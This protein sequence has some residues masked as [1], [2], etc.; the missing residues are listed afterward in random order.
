M[1]NIFYRNT[2]LLILTIVLIIFWGLSS[3]QILPRLED[4]EL[5]PRLGNITTIFP[6]A[7]AER[8]ES[9]IT[10][11]IEDELKEIEAI[12]LISSVSRLGLSFITVELKDEIK[13]I[14]L[15]WSQIR[16][17]L[18]DVSVKLPAGSS[19]PEFE[20][21]KL[22][23]YSMILALTWEQND[24]VNYA[25]LRRQAELL[26]NELRALPG[27]EEVELRGEPEEEIL[28]EIDHENLL[29]LGLNT[30][31]LAQ[32]IKASD[33]K[34]SSGK[35]RNNN[36]DLLLEIDS[37]IDS[38][39]RIRQIPIST[40]NQGLTTT[41]GNIAILKKGIIEPPNDIA[42]IQGKE[43]IALT[44]IVR[45]DY[46]L[47][48]WA[49]NAYQTIN[50]FQ[51][52]L[53]TGLN[54]QIIFDQS[55]YVNLRLDNLIFNLI[56][57]A[58]LVFLITCLMMGLKSAL[59][60][61]SAL[62]LSG[63]IVFGCMRLFNIPLHQMSITGL[64]VALGLLI[65]NAIVMVDEVQ[66]HL[67][68]GI[69][70]SLAIKKSVNYLKIPL[71]SST[72]TTVLAFL[73]IALLP[74]PTGEFVGTI[75]INVIIALFSSLLLS[76]TIIPALTAKFSNSQQIN[77]NSWLQKGIDV[78]WLTKIYSKSLKFTFKRPILGVFLALI[79]PIFGFLKFAELEEQFFPVA[80]RDQFQIELE[81]PAITSINE[82]H[83]LLKQANEIVTSHQEVKEIHWFAGR[84]APKFYYNLIENK[85]NNASYA[86]ALVEVESDKIVQSLIPIIQKEL[87]QKFPQSRVL[88]KQLE[89]GPPFNAPVEM[90]IYGS[91]LDVL[92]NL[93]S[94]F[95]RELALIN[96]VTFTRDSLGEISPQFSLKVDE[97]KARLVGLDN[98]KIA[99]QLNDNLEGVI[100]GS[101]I[102]DTEEIPIRVRLSNSERGD[103][104]EINSLD[105]ASNNAIIPFSTVAHMEITPQSNAIA[106]RNGQ[107]VNIVQAFI[108]VGV[109][110][111]Q[112]LAD[113]KKRLE[114]IN[115]QLPQGYSLELGG[116]AEERNDAVGG[117]LS[118]VGVLV[119]LMIITLVLSL[120]S[121]TLAAIIGVVGLCSIGL[122]LLSLWL[123]NYPFGF[124]AII[125]TIGL[126]GVAI[127]DS[128]V[129]ISAIKIH[130]QASLGNRRAVQKVVLN[131]TRH[132]VATT[133]TTAIGF[134]PLLLGGGGFWPPLAVAIAGGIFGA[135]LM[136]LYFIPSAYLLV[137]K[138]S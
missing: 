60:V 12:D 51:N 120:G 86:Q 135:T 84:S 117:L 107:R 50:E 47:D 114:T 65:D 21:G 29:S 34:I 113:F 122:G 78:P 28:V 11:K 129:V 81:L 137:R 49:K 89:Q 133:L 38:L 71:L 70:P 82:T 15:Y 121:F 45:S 52:K 22:K 97:T 72:L 132:V 136:A 76:L 41:L 90:R 23:G 116:E 1:L 33:A 7:S 101:I 46:R 68:E 53:S 108:E 57:G 124:M 69:K 4:P 119:I 95:R 110:P 24:P 3:F 66:H 2:R 19:E 91:D 127:N 62:P 99:Q 134:V 123:F 56:L 126:V 43:A 111:A 80:D 64:I 31:N 39:E 9:L 131:S 58:I 106:R 74:G 102:E 63:L 5:I 125:G 55:K 67:R 85:K 14:D 44:V 93:G 109:L 130:P 8:V 115:F 6:G 88:V 36:Q 77:S 42:I 87:N 35:I 75:A 104:E 98:T 32:Q 96:H 59:I 27:T 17:K 83:S 54:L 61:G 16:D 103:L 10:E 118:F 100:G 112:V 26:E 128:I 138:L 25:I 92:Q 37:E 73:P 40:D 18:N 105:L 48:K 20:E 79:L 13:D 30:Q 94:V